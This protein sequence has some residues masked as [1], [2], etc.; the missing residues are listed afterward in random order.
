MEASGNPALKKRVKGKAEDPDKDRQIAELKKAG[1]HLFP[2]LNLNVLSNASCFEVCLVPHSYFSMVLMLIM[3]F[4]SKASQALQEQ[5]AQLQATQGGSSAS[6]EAYTA[7]TKKTAAKPKATPKAKAQEGDAE[8]LSEAAKEARLRRVC[9]RKP[10]GKLHVPLEVH[11]QW[12]N[13]GA[14]RDALLELLEK[15]NWKKDCGCIF[16]QDLYACL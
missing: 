2:S 4:N 13:K 3:R 1:C 5:L 11:Q 7:P 15:C 12:L 6:T 9:E 16:P 10:S 14:G 8:E